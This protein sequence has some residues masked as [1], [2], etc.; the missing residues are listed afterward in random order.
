M[1]SIV[2]T[3]VSLMAFAPL[4]MAAPPPGH[5]DQLLVKF[6][7]T[8]T[9]GYFAAQRMSDETGKRMNFVKKSGAWH[10]F[11]LPE[12]ASNQAMLALAKAVSA[13]SGVSFA[14]PDWIMQKNT[15][16]DDPLYDA[17]PQ[18]QWHYRGPA[19]GEV[20][21]MNLLSTWAALQSETG[22]V[23][24]AVLDTGITDHPDL[25][26][27]VLAGYDAISYTSISNDGDG[28]DDDP[29]DP[30]DWDQSGSSSW[31]GTHV[32]GTIAADT[33][34]A[35]GVA[36]VGYNRLKVVPVRVLGQGG[37]YSSDIAWG[38][39]WVTNEGGTRRADVI[40]MSL[41]GGYACTSGS[42]YQLAINRAYNAGIT[43]VVAAGNSNQDAAGFSPASCENVISVASVNREG[44]K[45]YYSNYGA[46]VD[47]AAP[48]GD[49]TVTGDLSGWNP[50]L[51]TSAAGMVLSTLNTGTTTPGSP[52]YAFYQGTSMAAPHVAALAGLAYLYKPGITPFEVESLMK[53]HSRSFVASCS[54][55]GA[56]MADAALFLSS[57][58]TPIEPPP[59]P[60][61]IPESPSWN[62]SS[63][64]V[65]GDTVN[66]AWWDVEWAAEYEIEVQKRNKR[67][68]T[69]FDPVVVVSGDVLSYQHKPGDGDFRY[70]IRAANGSGNSGWTESP[71]LTVSS[72]DDGGG[73][74]GGKCH[75]KR[76]C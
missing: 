18:Y 21:G 10:I 31:H 14:E 44:G 50:S 76:G 69:S 58:D 20:A 1:R 60:D 25:N 39:D 17:Y 27:N 71:I 40:N 67:R 75:P 47:I 70:R 68:W 12:A 48:G 30:G 15:V 54:Q 9:D 6:D 5:T 34:N 73:G 72:G 64:P 37:G 46:V 28:R 59:E 23:K 55:C 41:G 22:T 16:P 19:E 33:N 56:G 65:S 43:V 11:R 24:V 49:Y 35:E 62:L 45:A 57:L 7:D 29:S 8:G 26:A 74:G 4:S 52:S 53:Q 3:A 2:M 63:D 36:G 61:P 13:R 38:I 51:S 32:A 42:Y 66:L